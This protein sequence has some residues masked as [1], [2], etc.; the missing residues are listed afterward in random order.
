MA[1]ILNS[2]AD[3]R[4]ATEAARVLVAQAFSPAVETAGAV[5]AVTLGATG[6]QDEWD[7]PNKKFG[8]NVVNT[9]FDGLEPLQ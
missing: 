5:E 1:E 8:P 7:H 3:A 9:P 4:L 6:R 2:G